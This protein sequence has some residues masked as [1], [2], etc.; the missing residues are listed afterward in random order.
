MV[1]HDIYEGK[2]AR[3]LGWVGIPR[4]I[5]RKD[6]RNISG[7]SDVFAEGRIELQDASEVSLGVSTMAE[8]IKN[9][10]TVPYDSYFPNQN[11]TRSCWQRAAWSSTA[12]RRQ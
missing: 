5:I 9:Y 3:N 10:Q 2:G 6:F 8:E 4:D 12:V 7:D 11:Q 1:S